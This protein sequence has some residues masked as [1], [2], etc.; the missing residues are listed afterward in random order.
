MVPLDIQFKIPSFHR[1]IATERGEIFV[2]GGTNPETLKRSRD[3][4]KCDYAAATL[5]KVAELIIPRSSHSILC[6]E[7]TIY[8]SGGMTNNDE[9]LKKCEAFN[10]RTD[11]VKAIASCKY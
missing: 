4:Y 10:P 5:R 2:I 1:T 3:I 8:I 6:H 7:G 11:E 9:T